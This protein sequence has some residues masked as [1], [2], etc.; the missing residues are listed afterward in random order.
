MIELRK[1]AKPFQSL[2]AKFKE[3][4]SSPVLVNGLRAR[5]FGNF[6]LPSG[7]SKMS[8]KNQTGI[9]ASTR[10]TR[11]ISNVQLSYEVVRSYPQPHFYHTSGLVT[12]LFPQTFHYDFHPPAA[13]KP[14]LTTSGNHLHPHP[15]KATR[16]QI[17]HQI[18]SRHNRNIPLHPAPPGTSLRRCRHNP[19]Q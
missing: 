18:L 17:E 16:K 5:K 14:P 4:L 10:N 13:P 2:S 15:S 11:H 8:G 19:R 7:S 3:S 1:K 9:P 6:S 12:H